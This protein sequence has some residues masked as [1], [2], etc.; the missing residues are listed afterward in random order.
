MRTSR[1]RRLNRI[2]RSH[3]S[4]PLSLLFLTLLLAL[5]AS[6]CLGN[7]SE[8]PPEESMCPLC[9]VLLRRTEPAPLT[10]PV[11]GIHLGRSESR[12]GGIKDGKITIFTGHGTD[13]IHVPSVVAWTDEGLVVGQAARQ[14][15]NAA[16]DTP[17]LFAAALDIS[18]KFN[19][20]Q[21]RNSGG[22][23]AT[24]NSPISYT[25][26]DS[27]PALEVHTNST[28]HTF[29]PEEIY[30]SLLTELV[31]IAEP[32]IGPNITSAVVALP[33]GATEA[34]RDSIAAAGTLA[35]LPIM[36]INE[37]TATM[38]ALGLDE[39]SYEKERLAL[40]FDMAEGF[41]LSVVEADMGVMD[42]IASH[43]TAGKGGNLESGEYSAMLMA[44]LTSDPEDILKIVENV[45]PFMNADLGLGGR[46]A[47]DE[48][49]RKA[50][51]T[52]DEITDL[53]FS[54]GSSL[55]K[56]VQDEIE[57]YI[58][59]NDDGTS[60]KDLNVG[61]T[62]MLAQ[63]P[64][65]G[66][67]VLA[68]RRMDLDWLP[69]CCTTTR[70][71]IGIGVPGGDVVEIIPSCSDLPV[72]ASE[73]FTASCNKHGSTLIQVYMRD[74][75]Y[76][77]YHAMIELGDAYEPW[78]TITDILL[79]EFDLPTSCRI[80]S[81]PPKIEVEMFLSRQMELVVKA[82]ERQSREQGVT[83]TFPYPGFECGQE[84]DVPRNYTLCSSNP[85]AGTDLEWR[86][87][88]ELRQ[89]VGGGRAQKP[90]IARRDEF[91][92]GL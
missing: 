70:P 5:S 77:D 43:K 52:K 74:I 14:A 75:P 48:V 67:V 24:P 9:P 27:K 4:S 57:R 2:A 41:D 81:K 44:M 42:T 30:A 51:L 45:V 1:P 87:Q 36:R 54:G 21:D 3:S 61:S 72:R 20:S 18:Q 19:A 31:R 10:P 25:L 35:G 82:T 86:Y 6:A 11:I 53:I 7:A 17:D 63:A 22:G 49:L 46:R 15:I 12:V 79:A 34:D 55:Y 29:L 90:V 39:I 65:W 32:E 56:D 60:R 71:P 59:T 76:V 91:T 84:R 58:V 16:K 64:V 23:Q 92:F 40:F 88:R 80:G 78:T 28:R 26:K 89:L 66:S 37:T 47:V 85:E 68:S 8:E 83:L 69:C 33:H 62:I 13:A 38:I 50:N 73:I